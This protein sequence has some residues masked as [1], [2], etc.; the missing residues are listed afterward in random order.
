[1]WHNIQLNEIVS[2]HGGKRLPSGHDYAEHETDYKYLR[3]TDFF[4]KMPSVRELNSLNKETFN[5]LK[6]YEIK[7]GDLYISIA[8]SIGLVG[9]WNQ[10]SK[11]QVILTENAARLSP[12]S[13]FCGGFIAKQLNSDDVQR[14]IGIEIGTGGG[15]PKLALF[16]IEK[17][18]IKLPDIGTQNKIYEILNCVDETIEK[19]EELIAKYEQIKQGM[20]HDVFTRGVDENG[21]LRP[22]YED[23]AELYKDTEIGFIPKEWSIDSLGSVAQGRPNSFVDGPFG[24]DLKTCDYTVDGVRILQLQ[25][26]GDGN[27]INSNFIYTS[28]EKASSLSRCIVTQGDIVIAKMAEPLARAV[29][30]PNYNDKYLIVADLMKLKVD[31]SRHI[32]HF[33]KNYINFSKFRK[34]AERLSTGTTRTRISL[35]VLK[36]IE[37]GLPEKSEQIQ[38]SSVI[39]T[40]ENKINLENEYLHKLQKKKSGLMQDLLTGKVSVNVEQREAA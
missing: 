27:F 33:I 9:E 29:L 22:S 8:G 6:R 18:K 40:I 32:P 35:S 25:N 10:S 39:K 16:R 3:V 28:E 12:V 31:S 36:K 24:S 11:H 26:L 34:E 21:K 14:Q 37:I 20:M 38:I 23:A 19:T 4:Q 2:V 15:V 17:L 13:D 1:M 30:V 5:A 7:N